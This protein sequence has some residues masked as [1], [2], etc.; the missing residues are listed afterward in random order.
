MTAVSLL[1]EECGSTKVNEVDLDALT[2]F[3]IWLFGIESATTHKIPT[4]F[5]RNHDK[6]INIPIERKETVKVQQERN[7]VIFTND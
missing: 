5:R 1:E 7:A 3:Q 6:E 4:T 2:S